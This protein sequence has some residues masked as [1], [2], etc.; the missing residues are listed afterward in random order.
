MR[1]RSGFTLVEVLIAVFLIDIGLLALV[2]ASSVIVRQA[3][4]LRLR[5]IAVRA[6]TN[7]LQQLGGQPCAPLS[8]GAAIAEG[9]REDWS[10]ASSFP[11]ALDVQ[12]SVT[13]G[14]GRDAHSV[15]LRTKL[16]C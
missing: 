3:N 10:A 7:R 1:T 6:A 2:A 5:N 12:D 13:I 9:I 11:G 16:P 4:A 8:G 15:V 14:A